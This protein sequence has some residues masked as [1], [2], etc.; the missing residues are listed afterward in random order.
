MRA[1]RPSPAFAFA[2]RRVS[3]P[4]SSSRPTS[5]VILQGEA[6][7]NN[8]RRV[9]RGAQR[10]LVSA[11][12][13]PSA[14][15]R[16]SRGW[17][18]LAASLQG[19]ACPQRRPARAIPQKRAA[20]NRLASSRRFDVRGPRVEKKRRDP[21]VPDNLAGQA[22]NLHGGSQLLSFANQDFGD[23]RL[24]LNPHIC[25]NPDNPGRFNRAWP[26][27]LLLTSFNR[28]WPR[29]G[30]N[31]RCPQKVGDEPDHLRGYRR[32]YGQWTR[33]ANS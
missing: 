11:P 9:A 24:L 15:E 27:P 23:P 5:E 14:S 32:R 29:G 22:K 12:R 4:S 17:R 1:T 3:S 10:R 28:R 20:Q 6:L 13:P 16:P 18:S 33:A 19:P 31:V 21:T 25:L 8:S 2:H 30:G 7:R 26:A